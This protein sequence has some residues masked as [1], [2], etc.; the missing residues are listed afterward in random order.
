MPED[1]RSL[2]LAPQPAGKAQQA[3]AA[4]DGELTVDYGKVKETILCKYNITEETHLQKFRS[5]WKGV[6][7]LYVDLVIRL[8][9]LASKWLRWV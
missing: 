2:A 3:Y 7:E 5:T 1:Q 6:E 8:R 9:D 4:M